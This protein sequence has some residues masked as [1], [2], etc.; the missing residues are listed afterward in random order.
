[1]SNIDQMK[2]KCIE[3]LQEVAAYGSVMLHSIV[4][5]LM[6]LQ[7]GKGLPVKYRTLTQ[8]TNRGTF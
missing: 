5:E 1:M 7:L 2:L 4:K 3:I 8:I 6:V